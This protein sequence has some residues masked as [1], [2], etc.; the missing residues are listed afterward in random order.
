MATAYTFGQFKDIII[1]HFEMIW[2]NAGYDLDAIVYENEV[3]GNENFVPTADKPIWA[4]LEISV[5][6]SSQPGIA[7]THNRIF[8]REGFVNILLYTKAGTGTGMSDDAYEAIV[9]G[10]EGVNV[11]R[12]IFINTIYHRRKETYKEWN[13]LAIAI[14]YT[15]D[16][17]K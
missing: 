17:H 13:R 11:G 5:D 6:N 7:G 3:K 2:G 14:G 4:Y 8:S 10:F 1:D 9:T 16:V 12:D 15:W